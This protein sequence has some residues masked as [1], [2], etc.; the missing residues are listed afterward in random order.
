LIVRTYYDEI[1]D[2]KYDQENSKIS[3]KMPFTWDLDYV[4]QVVFIHQEI[5]IPKSYTQLSNVSSFT[6]ALNGNKLPENAVFIDDYSDQ[7]NRSV[8]L[9]VSNVKLNEVTNQIIKAGIN[10]YAEFELQPLLN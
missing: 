8:H 7:N 5:I 9:V 4:N 2:F 10:P 6:G 3:F 1:V